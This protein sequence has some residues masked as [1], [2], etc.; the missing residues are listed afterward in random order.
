MAPG[1]VTR[2][3]PQ[4]GRAGRHMAPSRGGRGGSGAGSGD[5]IRPVAR[6]PSLPPYPCPVGLDEMEPCAGWPRTEPATATGSAEHPHAWS[7]IDHE[8]DVI[9]HLGFPGYFLV[10]WDIVDFAADPTSTA[11]VGERQRTVRSAMRSASPRP[12]RWDSGCCSSGSCRRSATGRPTSTSTS[13]RT[14][15]RRPSS[16][17]TTATVGTTAQVANVITYRLLVGA[18]HRQ[19]VRVRSGP[20]GRLVEAGRRGRVE[21]TTAQLKPDGTPTTTS[22][23]PCSSS[24]PR[25]RTFP[26]PRHPLRGMVICDRPVIEVCPVE[27]ARMDRCSVLQWDK[28]DCAATGLVKFDLLSSGCCRPCTTPSI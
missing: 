23:P 20:A 24:P 13:N 15:A 25:S 14:A 8:L 11:R 10:V 6:R 4:R 3:P 26:P 21:A 9:E 18:R 2:P 16:T 22:R 19:G 1:G 27:W 12:M 28:D 7:V 17:C 5:R